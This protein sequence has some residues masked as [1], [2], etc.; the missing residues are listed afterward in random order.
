MPAGILIKIPPP[1]KVTPRALAR[2]SPKEGGDIYFYL[3]QNHPPPPMDVGGGRY[4]GVVVL[5]LNIHP[6]R[7]QRDLP[8]CWDG[9]RPNSYR[10]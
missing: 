3:D 9:V 7:T 6:G 4:G 1:P 2:V 8:R 5:T 10:Y